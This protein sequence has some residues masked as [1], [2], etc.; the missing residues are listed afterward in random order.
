MLFL[1]FASRQ[2]QRHS[3]ASV[4]VNLLAIAVGCGRPSFAIFGKVGDEMILGG[5]GLCVAALIYYCRYRWRQTQEAVLIKHN[6]LIKFKDNYLIL[7]RP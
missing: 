6:T 2:S 7:C 1:T 5:L 3:S 4:P